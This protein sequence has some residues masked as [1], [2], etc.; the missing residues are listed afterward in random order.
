M[1][2]VA[3]GEFA[4][5]DY[6]ALLYVESNDPARPVIAIVLQMHVA[7]PLLAQFD[8]K[9]GKAGY[10]RK[11][12][13][14]VAYWLGT[15][16][17]ITHTWTDTTAV[18]G[19]EY[20]YA[21]C[22]YDFG[23]DSPF[24]SLAFYPS[25][26]S[27][28]VSRTPRGGVILPTNVVRVRPGPR[29]QGFVRAQAD[30]AI[31]VLGDG[32]GTL[33]VDVVNSGLVPDGHLFTVSF[34]APSPDSIRATNYTLRDS[35]AHSTIFTT[36]ADLT[37]QG[38]GAVGIGLQPSVNTP[39][40]PEIN[41]AASGYAVGSPTNT[42]IK[43]LWQPGLS[44]N[45]RRVGYPDDL[46]IVFDDVVRDTGLAL[47]PVAA[48][49]AKFR[50]IAHTPT[51]DAQLDFRFNDRDGNGTLSRPD[52]AI[53]IVT[54]APFAPT[55]PQI[56]YRITL[57]TLGQGLRG[58]IVPPRLGDTYEMK[59]DRPLGTADQFVFGTNGQKVADGGGRGFDTK[60]YVVPNPYVGA[61]SFEPERFAVS[62]RGERRIE[63]RAIPLGATIRIYTVDG[64]LVQTLRQDGSNEGYVAWNLRTKD[65]LDMAPG[66]YLFHVDAPGVGTHIGKFAVVK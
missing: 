47:F 12:V 29:V 4:P 22:A 56:T 41:L 28:T 16:S 17:G 58:A 6:Y 48:R 25:E 62:G 38:N 50:V 43:P 20:Y 7:E 45:L 32:I 2:Q 35:T 37:G 44:K 26:N 53:D 18:N 8:L 27:I 3:A 34:T 14:G 13:E 9:D 42:R 65:N 55:V 57:D 52:E 30:T 19:Q 40:T 49:A 59:V 5:G 15:E 33:A 51:G 63:F 66:L 1:I 60:P 61:A 21:V 10:S 46:S 11:T 24:D 64:D 31:H 39:L 36:G 54:Y 23:F